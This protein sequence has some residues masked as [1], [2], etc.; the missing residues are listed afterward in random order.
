MTN[1]EQQ[2]KRIS[3]FAKI[4]GFDLIRVAPATI[5]RKYHSCFERWISLKQHGTMTY[6]SDRIEKK[7]TLN[8]LLPGVKSVI[9]LGINYYLEDTRDRSFG[10]GWVSRYACT[11]DYHKTIKKKLRCV[12]EFINESYDATAKYYVDTGPILERAYA[13]TAGVGYIGKNTCLITEQ[14]GSWVFLAEI[15]TTLELPGDTNT[16]KINCG[17][18][19]R[20]ITHCPTQAI[21]DDGTIDARKCIS[22]LT[23]EN[24][25]GIPVQLRDK[26]GFWL[27]GCD[28]CQEVCPHNGRQIP[29]DL[30]YTE[31]RIKDRL[32]SLNEILK[33]DSDEEFHRIFAGTPLMAGKTTGI[34]T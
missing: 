28:I 18:C 30:S 9:T 10:E 26:I 19:T 23:I 29:A 20:C 7:T 2:K 3:E 32:L 11:R 13:E 6:L 8:T 22:Y 14:Y 17:T 31:I 15:L 16:L 24:K 33:V 1:P 21:N 4:L 27:F 34:V 25:D 5:A 12:S